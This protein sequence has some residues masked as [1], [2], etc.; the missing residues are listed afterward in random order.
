MEIKNKNILVTG[1]NRGIGK[2]LVEEFLSRGVSKV[3]AAARNIDTL[4][5]DDKRV[6]KVDLDVTNFKGIEKTAKN[7][8]TLDILINNAGVLHNVPILG[9]IEKLDLAREEIEVNYLGTL[10][11]CN[12]FWP[13][14]A[15][16][17][18]DS[19]KGSI[20]NI[21]SALSKVTYPFCGTYC[22]SKHATLALTRGLRAQLKELHVNILEVYPGLTDTDMTEG[23]DHL[24]KISPEQVAKL[25]ID[26]IEQDK[27]EVYTGDDAIEMAAQIAK[28]PAEA[29]NEGNQYMPE[30]LKI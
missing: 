3:Y 16:N 8:P 20:V 28:D 23:L 13:I 27:S 26:G 9:N 6:T 14:V 2:C 12:I 29:Q 24:P 17:K 1:A 22:A 7:I 4:K 10:N 19:N 5:F 30:P 11:V 18:S 25:T 21:M 15:K